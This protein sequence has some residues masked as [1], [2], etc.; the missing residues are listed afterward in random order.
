MNKRL[1]VLGLGATS[2]LLVTLGSQAAFA[3]NVVN[4]VSAT[5][6]NGSLV[7]PG[8]TTVGYQIVQG[9]AGGDPQAGCNV[10]D[11]TPA[12]VTINAPAEV[13]ATPSSVKF[14]K[15][16]DFKNVVFTANAAGDYNIT[17]TVTDTGGGGYFTN[18]AAFTLKVLAG[19]TDTTAPVIAPHGNETAEATGPSGATVIY[20]PPATSDAVDGAGTATC[21]LPPGS[22]FALGTTTVTCDAT[23][24]AGNAATP[25]TFTVTVRDTTAPVIAAHGSV[26]ATAT[27]QSS[28]V[29]SYTSPA[30][31]DAVDGA[32]TATCLPASG[33][34]FA[35]G[36]TTVTCNASDAAG[37]AATPTT[38]SVIVTYAWSGFYQ[39]IDMNLNNRAKAG[40][41]IPVKFSLGGNQGL[42]IFSPELPN[43]KFSFTSCLGGLV[44]DIEQIVTAGASSLTYD[45]ASDQYVYVWKT[46]KAWAGKCGTLSVTLKDGSTHTASFTLTK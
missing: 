30:T 37:N 23:D 19:A 27:S 24:A 8:S 12:T 31:S 11:G 26:T 36:T 6:G 32:G 18:P 15:C 33:S 39:P 35:V 38:F 9:N 34:T 28:A 41:A 40:S 2:A 45:A 4:N 46:D 25:T 43:P 22:T 44:D 10:E 5:V 29:V 42:N 20:T 21:A 7:L 17:I 14:D 13:T 3:D 1:K 16:N